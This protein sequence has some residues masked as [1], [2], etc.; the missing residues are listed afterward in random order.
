MLQFHLYPSSMELFSLYTSMRT[1]HSKLHANRY[2]FVKAYTRDTSKCAIL[3]ILYWLLLSK[4]LVLVILLN[5][6]SVVITVAT[7]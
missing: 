6:W 3:Y 4:Y 7:K 2:T 1:I 5:C